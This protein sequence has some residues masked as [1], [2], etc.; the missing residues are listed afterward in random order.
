MNRTRIAQK[1]IALLATIMLVVTTL[2]PAAP[3]V[4]SVNAAGMTD[5]ARIE[6][7]RYQNKP[8]NGQGGYV[9]FTVK[10]VDLSGNPLSFISED[11]VETAKNNEGKI[12]LARIKPAK[13]DEEYYVSE[14]RNLL[15]EEPNSRSIA[16]SHATIK[17][18]TAGTEIR[19]SGISTD[20]NNNDPAIK[21]N[22]SIWVLDE[23]GV[24]DT[25]YLITTDT[26]F[27]I[28]LYYDTN[29]EPRRVTNM[30]WVDE[31]GRQIKASE[32]LT[33]NPGAI[34]YTWD[35]VTTPV[36]GSELKLDTQG[37]VAPA[38]MTDSAGNTYY[39]TGTVYTA[40]TNTKINA[41][42]NYPIIK[43]D[44]STS[45]GIAAFLNQNFG[46]PNHTEWN[47]RQVT[48][49]IS[50]PDEVAFYDDNARHSGGTLTKQASI[51]G[52]FR[53]Y[54][55]STSVSFAEGFYDHTFPLSSPTD[56]GTLLFCYTSEMD[57]KY[58]FDASKVMRPGVDLAHEKYVDLDPEGTGDETLYDL[59]LTIQSKNLQKTAQPIDL[60]F[61]MDASGSMEY[62]FD[63]ASRTAV[64]DEEKANGVRTRMNN[65][66]DA[67]E[68]LV[69]DLNAMDAAGNIDIR[70]AAVYFGT[71]A[72]TGTGELNSKSIYHDDEIANGSREWKK[73]D[74]ADMASII[75]NDATKRQATNY[76]SALREAKK[77]FAEAEDGKP[78][79]RNAKKI[80]IFVTDGLPTQSLS[81]P[82]TGGGNG[83]GYTERIKE[84]IEHELETLTVDEFYA[85]GICTGTFMGALHYRNTP[86][87]S[88]TYRYWA[89][90][91][92]QSTT[93]YALKRDGWEQYPEGREQYM[94]PTID[95][96]EDLVTHVNVSDPVNNPPVVKSADTSDELRAAFEQIAAKD[97]G[98]QFGTFDIHDT[99]SEW[100][101]VRIGGVENGINLASKLGITVTKYDTT[102]H[103]PIPGDEQSAVVYSQYPGKPDASLPD[104]QIN[105]NNTLTLQ[106]Y[107]TDDDPGKTKPI[108]LT[109]TVNTDRNA[110][111]TRGADYG[112]LHLDFGP[113]YILNPA[114]EFKITLAIE[115]SEASYRTFAVNEHRMMIDDDL[116]D[117]G[118]T[119]SR[120][121]TTMP[122]NG[123][124]IPKGDAYDQNDLKPGVQT[125]G[126]HAGEAGFWSN[127]ED[128]DANGV[129][130]QRLEPEKDSTGKP[131][132]NSAG[133]Y[134][135]LPVQA[136]DAD[137][138]LI[139]DSG[140]NP[141]WDTRTTA[142]ATFSQ[143]IVAGF[144]QAQE[145][146]RGEVFYARPVIRVTD[147]EV[148]IVKVWNEED[149]YAEK[150]PS[151]VQFLL[152][153]RTRDGRDIPVRDAAGNVIYPN[154]ITLTD[155]DADPLNPDRW[156]GKFEHLPRTRDADI[157][158]HKE[159]V[160]Y[161]VYEVA[162]N[163]RPAY[164]H[165]TETY[166]LVYDDTYN[167]YDIA[168]PSAT[169][170][171]LW[172]RGITSAGVPRFTFTNVLNVA[173]LTVD[174][175]IAGLSATETM[176]D[177]EFEFTLE[178]WDATAAGG[179][180]WIPV[181]SEEI[182]PVTL[183]PVP[184]K[185]Y[186]LYEIDPVTKNAT[187]IPE[188]TPGAHR[189][190]ANGKFTLTA[191]QK[192]DFTFYAEQGKILRV[193]ETDPFLQKDSSGNPLHPY[194]YYA[195]PDYRYTRTETDH[196]KN[197]TGTAT[198]SN[199]TQTTT[200]NVLPVNGTIDVV[201]TNTVDKR[202]AKIEKEVTGDLGEKDHEFI[203]RAQIRNQGG[204]ALTAYDLG[205]IR[206]YRK[207]KNASETEITN[208]V[209]TKLKESGANDTYEFK[210]KHEEYLL[211]R[212]MPRNAEF[213]VT[214]VRASDLIAKAH[215]T[216]GKVSYTEGGSA[217]AVGTAVAIG[218]G[219]YSTGVV[220]AHD[221]AL[222]LHI[223]VTNRQQSTPP[224]EEAKSTFTPTSATPVTRLGTALSGNRDNIRTS[225]LMNY[226]AYAVTL[227]LSVIGIIIMVI[228]HRRRY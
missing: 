132:K 134:N 147:K 53:F 109:A 221:A 101:D 71:F 149:G 161:V 148:E 131:V 191:T 117:T 93:N 45:E 60:L 173:H 207:S 15:T 38:T 150:R 227:L 21:E 11:K 33:L 201:V 115:P 189:T 86:I 7:M 40:G 63:S 112:K 20:D 156:T 121:Q 61:V 138:N 34:E 130:K 25:E 196:H 88:W 188:P 2:A 54:R 17:E 103:T 182:D 178:E 160:P 155:S 104:N 152:F 105:K 85:I 128:L 183:Q 42:E 46:H 217:E 175:E 114:Y 120:Y 181:V 14:I 124:K 142:I 27:E 205:K 113:D 83:I 32:E 166:T 22:G 214:E 154:G 49:V 215:E 77:I 12:W 125:T 190:D 143:H 202:E 222:K 223:T 106:F 4:M 67:V 30:Y 192:A 75:K 194:I 97:F 107:D 187:L 180:K 31:R 70:Y 87:F 141:V 58:T 133:E 44:T 228:R 78:N 108:T 69:T 3:F 171:W 94:R 126:T 62:R 36:T 165:N 186:R 212:Y 153:E 172:S 203:F 213:T 91:D 64:T 218:G 18:V 74:A 28:K 9:T 204:A 39:Y 164:S 144:G 59:N 162:A 123:S 68:S 184:G 26:D 6:Y 200:A 98:S 23:A 100:A 56:G 168:P 35:G 224:P 82:A 95:F 163:V 116:Y 135:Y 119:T 118:I 51:T 210:L 52:L 208:E 136:R 169:D 90:D 29:A 145:D 84:D 226:A 8:E 225:D 102:T 170:D 5:S 92:P 198:E 55:L 195:N 19:T 220:K 179:G 167:R 127:A 73:W 197:V 140:G 146:E 96:L 110:D 151:S 37:P 209:V 137:G 158:G 122:V 1:S 211:V 10:T 80:L 174:K 193:T 79:G 16:F 185:K 99:L 199:V 219:D 111:G 41:P 177:K 176:D 13:D 50:D 157:Y 216:S 139:V 72:G 129:Q 66:H 57:G 47:L 48:R 65:L 76:Q 159:T 206:F 81:V 43:L 89:V 24:R